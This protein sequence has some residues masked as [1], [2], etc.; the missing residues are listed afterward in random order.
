[1]MT[2]SSRCYGTSP[3]EGR[4]VWRRVCA[5][6]CPTCA[7]RRNSGEST[8]YCSLKRRS[9]TTTTARRCTTSKTSRAFAPCRWRIWRTRTCSFSYLSS[10]FVPTYLHCLFLGPKVVCWMGYSVHLFKTTCMIV[11]TSTSHVVSLETPTRSMVLGV[12]VAPHQYI[13]LP[14]QH[15]HHSMA[16]PICTP[17]QGNE[18]AEQTQ[19]NPIP[20]SP[21]SQHLLR[22]LNKVIK[23]EF[24]GWTLRS[25]AAPL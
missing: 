11:H 10:L 7:R 22:I 12:V 15:T 2:T 24:P 5:L 20:S 4:R 1:M 17:L 18:K 23:H 13:K 25:R 16:S 6:S 8:W 21:S 3:R 19:P 9:R 14:V